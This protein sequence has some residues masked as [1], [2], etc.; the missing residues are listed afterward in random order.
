MSL[1]CWGARPL[2]APWFSLWL[3][4]PHPIL[5]WCVEPNG[6]RYVVCNPATT[7]WLVLLHSI[8]SAGLTRLGFDPTASSH[9]HVIEMSV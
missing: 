2:L 1:L 5:Y 8:H 4:W 9:F 6:F 7:K 3:Q